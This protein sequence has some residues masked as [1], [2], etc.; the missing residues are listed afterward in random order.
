MYSSAYF[1]EGLHILFDAASQ[2]RSG[3]PQLAYKSVTSYSHQGQGKVERFHWSLSD[4]LRATRPQW[5]KTSKLN[6]HASSRVT[7]LGTSTQ[8]LH[9]QQLPRTLFREDIT[10]R[11]LPL[12]LPLHI[13]GFGEIVLGDVRIIP[14]QKLHLR[15]QHGRGLITNEHILALPLQYSEHPS[16][17]TTW[18]YKRRQITHVPR[19]E[20]V[21]ATS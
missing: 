10:L 14:T 5:S 11:E 19:E 9:P 17:M 12:Q 15:S 8:H 3:R 7:S 18:A 2:H 4:Q 13:V 6:T 20:N 16:T 21:T 1:K